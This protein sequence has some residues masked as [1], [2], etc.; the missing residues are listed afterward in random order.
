MKIKIYKVKREYLIWYLLRHF[1]VFEF[2]N[3][4]FLKMIQLTSIPT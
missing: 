4:A 2:A 1:G 3:Y